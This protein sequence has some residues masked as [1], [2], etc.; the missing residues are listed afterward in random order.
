MLKATT[1]RHFKAT[2]MRHLGRKLIVGLIAP[3]IAV[4][5][6]GPAKAD[7]DAQE[8]Q[9]LRALTSAG[10]TITDPSGAISQGH[11]VCGEGLD[12]Q[13]SW[14][15]MRS[16]LMS[17]GYSR[18]D[19]STL[20]SKAVSVFCPKYSKVITEIAND[21]GNAGGGDQGD[22]GDQF[23]QSLKRNQRISI[24]KSAALDMAEAACRAPIAGVELYNAM[25]TMQQRYPQ[26]SI[27]AVGVVMS[28]GV[29][30]FC[31]ERLP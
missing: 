11:M 4:V 30:A 22:R 27:G 1:M 7:T 6:A 29:L 26:Y 24:G 12:H 20:I 17:W 14:Q 8:R 10:W 31:P 16:T 25:Q 19:A 3:L 13:V 9:F 15:E 28:Q 18:L 21:S 23:V 2:T 5:L